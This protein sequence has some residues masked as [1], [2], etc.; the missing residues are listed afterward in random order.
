MSVD[1]IHGLKN[2]HLEQTNNILPT[3]LYCTPDSK[4]CVDK[5]GDWNVFSTRLT[6]MHMHKVI[7]ING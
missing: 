6:Y 3:L 7:L 5:V 4:Y 2:V 1:L